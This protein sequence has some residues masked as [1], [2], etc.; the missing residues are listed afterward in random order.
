MQF[1]DSCHQVASHSC[2]IGL[3]M[4]F[5]SNNVNLDVLSEPA[6]SPVDN[7]LVYYANIVN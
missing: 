3:L 7:S 2:D 6:F 1:D 5:S 4:T